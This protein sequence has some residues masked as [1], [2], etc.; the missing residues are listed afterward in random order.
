[1]TVPIFLHR[2]PLRRRRELLLRASGA[3]VEGS[4]A[5]QLSPRETTELTKAT[6]HASR[7]NFDAECDQGDK[8]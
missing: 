4:V 1:M 7:V 6:G 3:D 5:M 2:G 8:H